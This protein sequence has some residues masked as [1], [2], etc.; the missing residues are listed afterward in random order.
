MK[1]LI[2][3]S[4]VLVLS[5]VSDAQSSWVSKNVGS[6]LVVRFPNEPNYDSKPERRL[7]L[8]TVKS[9]SSNC[10]FTVMVRSNA[11]P[12][13][14]DI[15]NLTLI[16]Q[17]E[18]VN[19]FL[20][21]GISQFIQNGKVVSPLKPID[22]RSFIGKELT[23]IQFD[24]SKGAYVFQYTRFIMVNNELYIIQCSMPT[25]GACDN[26]KNTFLNSTSIK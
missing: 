1:R 20:E 24:N 15:K 21:K 6:N 4:L 11:M 26:D 19:K 16:Q 5:T 3:C 12:N 14:N 23:Y 7:L 18:E 17:K 8:Y 13:Y 2:S 9:G 10:M 25:E 22:N